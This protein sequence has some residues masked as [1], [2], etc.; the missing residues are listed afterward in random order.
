MRKAMV[1]MVAVWLMVVVGTFFSAAYAE[2]YPAAFV[3]VD[4]DAD[5]D[6]LILAD[7][8]GNEWTW[9]GV[10]DWAIGDMAAAVMDDAGTSIIYDDAIITLH[11][12]GWLDG[13]TERA[14]EW[15]KR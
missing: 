6:L 3:V 10:E 2:T 11:Y 9:E 12:V 15:C 14:N 13:W 5:N 7:F 1:L 4:T 8:N